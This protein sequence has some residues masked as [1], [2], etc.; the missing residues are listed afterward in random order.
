MSSPRSLFRTVVNRN[1]PHETRIAAIDEL[2]DADATSQL[3]TIVVTDG[4]NGTYRRRAV[5]NLG[6]CRSF[7]EL[8]R[9]IDDVTVPPSLRKT[10][11]E[12]SRF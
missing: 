11:E 7:T 5:K 4:L 6:Q 1:T 3:H 12:V 2:A 10:V 8:E 9:L